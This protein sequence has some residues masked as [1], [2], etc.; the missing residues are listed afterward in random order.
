MEDKAISEKLRIDD[1]FRFSCGRELGCYNLCCRDINLFLTPYDILRVKRRLA[2]PSYEF[3]K[4]YTLPLFPEE[5]GHPVILLRMVPD[6]TKN[7]PF[8]SDEGCTIYDDR[9]WSCRSFPL[10]PSAGSVP[11]EFEIVKRDF[12]MG[13]DKGKDHS[14][15]KW[16]TSQNVGLY[17]EMNE[18]WKKVTHHENFSSQNLLEGHARDMFFLGSYNIDEFSNVVFK[19]DFLKYFDIDKKVLKNIK[20]SDTELLKFSFR[21]LRHALFG[22]DTLRR[23]SPANFRAMG[24]ADL[25]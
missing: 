6:G 17:E 18:E 4:T 19:G 16:R 14:I 11:Q 7:C 13:F 8:V 2:I 22:E 1:S 12:C 24:R 10:E 5:I 15:Q 23:K 3:L 21:W 25:L 9:P 20:A